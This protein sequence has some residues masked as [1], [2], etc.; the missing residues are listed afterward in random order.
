MFYESELRF[1]CEILKKCRVKVSFHSPEDSIM[2]VLDDNF[3]ILFID[4]DKNN[5]KI[6]DFLMEI[7]TNTIYKLSTPFKLNYLFFLLPHTT[8]DTIMT[9]GPFLSDRIDNRFI[10]EIG[11]KYFVSPTKQ[12]I[13]KDYYTSIPVLSESDCLFTMIDTFAERIWGGVGSFN[14]VDTNNDLYQTSQIFNKVVSDNQDDVL[15]N[16]KLMENR[17]AY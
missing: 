17:Y 8:N 3:K 4:D 7:N 2:K 9:I 10:L 16:M 12:K 5:T 11:E 14:M 15:V 1:L 13:L 6:N